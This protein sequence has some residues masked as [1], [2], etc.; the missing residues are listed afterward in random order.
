MRIIF[1]RHGHPDYKVDCLTEL[2]HL[3]AEAA[4]QRLKD[5]PISA[6]YS[7]TKGRAVETAEHI[8]KALRL[9][10]KESFDFMRELGWAPLDPED[11]LPHNGNPWLICDDLVKDGRSMARTDWKST[12]PFCR[13]MVINMDQRVCVGFDGLLSEYGLDREGEYY[14]VR[15]RNDSTIVMASHA[16]ASGMVF[17][18]LFN[19]PF[20]LVIKSLSPNFTAITVVRIDGEQGELVAPSFELLNDARHIKNISTHVFFGN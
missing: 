19:I 7:S 2:G 6:I 12:E 13:S 15:E 8:A 10:I 20:P 17:S 14:R 3:Q 1:V 9:P 18:H 11:T 16:G 4:A 5:E